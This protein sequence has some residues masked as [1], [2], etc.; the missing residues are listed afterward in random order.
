M[1]VTTNKYEVLVSFY[2]KLV[3]SVKPKTNTFVF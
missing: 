1:G 3:F 2:H